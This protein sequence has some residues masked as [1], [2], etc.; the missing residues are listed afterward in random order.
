[1]AK[2]RKPSPQAPRLG[3]PIATRRLRA[4]DNKR[5]VSIR[6]WAPKRATKMW[7]CAFFVTGAGMKEPETVFGNDSIQALQNAMLGIRL[8]LDKLHRRLTWAD[9]PARYTFPHSVPWVYGAELAERIEKIVAQEENAFVASLRKTRTSSVKRSHGG[10]ARS[11]R[12]PPRAGRG[13]A[14]ESPPRVVR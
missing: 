10:S 14:R 4:A 8:R 6:M 3:S 1:M 11:T 12:R 9:R 5:S 2:K 13:R 7:S